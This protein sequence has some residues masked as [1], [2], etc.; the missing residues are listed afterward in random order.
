MITIILGSIGIAVYIWNGFGWF[1]SFKKK[2]KPKSMP[3]PAPSNQDDF[4]KGIYREN[5]DNA[6]KVK[7]LETE[8]AH[9][10]KGRE[11]IQA[12]LDEFKNR[13]DDP[14]KALKK[15]QEFKANIKAD[16]EREG[17]RIGSEKMIAAQDALENG[18]FSKADDLFAEIEAREKLVVERSARAAFAR[19][20]IANQDVRLT[21][22]AEHYAR[23]A[24]LQP[25]FETLI[26]AHELAFNIGDYDS[27]LSLGLDAEKA[28]IK[29]YEKESE[30]HARAI[31][32]LA[33]L[34]KQKAQYK[35][36]E[37]LYNK[38][39]EIRKK[40]FG[41]SHPAVAVS[42]NNL[43]SVYHLQGQYEIAEPLYQQAIEINR[44][45]LGENNPATA[46]NLNNL[47]D[48]YRLQRQ[49]DK[50]EPLLKSA[51]KNHRN[52]FGDRHPS[53]ATSLNNLALLYDDMKRYKE[54]EELYDESLTICREVLGDN[55]P[56]TANSFNNL[57][58]LYFIQGQYAKAEPLCRKGLEIF[59]VIFGH[60]HP[61][62]KAAKQNYEILKECL[63]NAEKT[64]PQ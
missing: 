16:L 17:N 28:A 64:T 60:D 11:L 55:H 50:A 14:E 43:A 15:E 59:E 53:T 23:A 38:S 45:E 3:E 57:G 41:K 58:G 63:A 20:Q 26:I 9:E 31:N 21:D 54:S 62:T 37:L 8:L 34:Y 25:C 46:N 22:A 35:D 30:Q 52:T 2:Q 12:E 42:L 48:L 6:V 7:G 47:A 56:D 61:N 27:A 32:D 24:Q 4:A 1:F 51:I 40:L 10:K 33:T 18:D 49:Y 36:A 39:L 19:G 44:N 13:Q 29:D 5:I